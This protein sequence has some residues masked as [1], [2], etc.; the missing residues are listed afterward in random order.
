MGPFSDGGPVWV[1]LLSSW[2]R[3]SF[4]KRFEKIDDGRFLLVAI[5][6]VRT[7]DEIAVF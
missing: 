1:Q 4:P 7:T 6:T 5:S 3:L 2:L